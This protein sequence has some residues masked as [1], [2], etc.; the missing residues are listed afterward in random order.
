VKNGATDSLIGLLPNKYDPAVPND[1]EEFC[2][3]RFLK[4]RQ[5]AAERTEKRRREEEESRR[6]ERE[7]RQKTREEA[8]KR[9]RLETPPS[10]DPGSEHPG[11]RA[12]P[13]PVGQTGVD[14]EDRASDVPFAQ[15]MMKD[16]GWQQGQGLGKDGKGI[17]AALEHQKTGLRTANI[18]QQEAPPAP[19][20]AAPVK[21]AIKVKGRPTRVL[22]LLNMVGPGEVDEGL[23]G[24]IE[25]ECTK[26]GPVEKVSI[27]ESKEPDADPTTAVRIFAKFAKQESSMK[28]LV[29]LN[30]RNFGGRQ[31]AASFF[32]VDKF[33][34]GEL[35]P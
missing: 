9:R 8:E 6:L 34:A 18:V 1:Y 28:A 23:Q 19:K 15:R 3:N 29:D 10:V 17:N 35:E 5:A 21:K 4:E 14:A 22:L 33:D 12:P 16:W 24:E 7:Q 31:I 13:N 11:M 25:E 27:L 20:P 32:A 26:Y 30:G 2:K